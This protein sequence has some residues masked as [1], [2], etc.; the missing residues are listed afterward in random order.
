MND[1]EGEIKTYIKAYADG[2][3]T[4][5]ECVSMCSDVL[6]RLKYFLREHFDSEDEVMDYMNKAR[7]ALLEDLTKAIN[8]YSFWTPS[9][10][11]I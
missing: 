2:V 1:F 5:E 4:F 8:D 6:R 9:W 7:I 10:F 3:I 11:R